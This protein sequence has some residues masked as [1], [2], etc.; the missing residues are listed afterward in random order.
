MLK[1]TKDVIREFAADN[2][3]Y[4]E[5]RSTPRGNDTTGMSKRDYVEAV[6][7]AIQECNV[8]PELD[9]QVR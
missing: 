7:R 5:L 8:D 1:V 6:I 3:K 2:V 9:I 4:L